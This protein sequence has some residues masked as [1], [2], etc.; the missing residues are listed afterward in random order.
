MSSPLGQTIEFEIGGEYRRG[1]VK[2][3]QQIAD[4]L[5]VYWVDVGGGRIERHV[6]GRRLVIE[7]TALAARIVA[8]RPVHGMSVNEQLRALAAAV[9]ETAIAEEPVR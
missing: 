9:L 4:D 6:A 2:A 8:G 5:W 1:E 7:P 3:F